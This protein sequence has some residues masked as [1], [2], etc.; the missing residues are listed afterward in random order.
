MSLQFKIV[1]IASLFTEDGV[2]LRYIIKF[3]Q[4]QKTTKQAESKYPKL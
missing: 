3:L 2:V 4:Q 1:L